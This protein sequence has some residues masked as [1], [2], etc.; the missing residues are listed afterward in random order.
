MNTFD[1]NEKNVAKMERLGKVYE[2]SEEDKRRNQRL[3]LDNATREYPLATV[4]RYSWVTCGGLWVF[5]IVGFIFRLD[6]RVF[7]PALFVSLGVSVAL[8]IPVFLAKRKIGDVI[9]GTIVALV[10]IGVAVS[11]LIRR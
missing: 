1:R 2:E 7:I 6:L 3:S 10:C 5:C 11:L 9:M 8:N 4:R